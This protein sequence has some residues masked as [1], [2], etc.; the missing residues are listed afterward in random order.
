MFYLLISTL[1][2]I[3]YT[4]NSRVRRAKFSEMHDVDAS[5]VLC[6]GITY[7]RRPDPIKDKK[8]LKN[9]KVTS[10]LQFA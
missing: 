2:F 9:K 4:G 1:N 5:P 7:R 3:K 8:G 6:S 10:H